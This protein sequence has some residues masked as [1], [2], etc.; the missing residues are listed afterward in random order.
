MQAWAAV[1]AACFYCTTLLFA[2]PLFVVMLTIAPF[3]HYLDSH[4]CAPCLRCL[5]SPNWYCLM[6]L[7]LP[8]GAGEGGSMQS[9][10]CGPS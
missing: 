2:T 1:R 8:L 9:I 3:V 5:M 6:T 10:P 7:F 4:R